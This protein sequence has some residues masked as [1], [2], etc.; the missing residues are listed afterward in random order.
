V[1]LFFCRGPLR[2]PLLRLFSQGGQ[3]KESQRRFLSQ[4]GGVAAALT[5]VLQL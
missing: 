1:D 3:S 2:G 4:V 5:L